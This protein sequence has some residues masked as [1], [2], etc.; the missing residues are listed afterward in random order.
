M[1]A[2]ATMKV[3]VNAEKHRLSGQHRRNM[4][5]P[6]ADPAQ[7][8]VRT[9]SPEQP[10]QNQHQPCEKQSVPAFVP[11]PQ[12][13]PMLT[14]TL[15]ATHS[16][17]SSASCSP[18]ASTISS[19]SDFGS[20][21]ESVSFSFFSPLFYDQKLFIYHFLL[22]FYKRLGRCIQ[23]HPAVLLMLQ[24]SVAAIHGCTIY[25]LSVILSVAQLIMITFTLENLDWIQAHK[26][27]ML[28]WDSRFPGF[29]FPA[30]D[31]DSAD[32]EDECPDP[33]ARRSQ[34][35]R[36]SSRYWNAQASLKGRDDLVDDGYQSEEC[37]QRWTIRQ[38]MNSTLRKRLAK[39]QQWIPS[40][41]NAEENRIQ[42]DLEQE[43]EDD[44]VSAESQE[45]E[46]RYSS[47]LRRALVRTLSGNIRSTNSKRVTFNEQVLVFGRRRSSQASQLSVSSSAV[48]MTVISVDAARADIEDPHPSAQ[49]EDIQAPTSI[50]KQAEHT[51][52]IS[53]SLTTGDH[54]QLPALVQDELLYQQMI[55]S[56]DVNGSGTSSPLFKL[57]HSRSQ[58][59]EV[60]SPLMSSSS[61][62][63]APP[64][65]VTARARDLKRSISVPMKIGSFLHRHQQHN[66]PSDEPLQ[67]TPRHS[68]TFSE[69]STVS[70]NPRALPSHLA[71]VDSPEVELGTEVPPS[72]RTLPLLSLRARRSLSLGTARPNSHPSARPSAK[73]DAGALLERQGSSSRTNKNFMYRIVHPQRYKRELEQQWTEQ[74]QQRLLALANLQHRHILAYDQEEVPTPSST[75]TKAAGPV[76]CGDAYYYATSAEYIED[77]GAPN[78]VISTS[79][80]ISF[81]QELQRNRSKN[82][83]KSQQRPASYDF[84]CRQPSLVRPTGSGY[85][86]EGD[87]VKSSPRVEQIQ[88][89]QQQQHFSLFKRG[90]KKTG[91]EQRAQ[92][93]NRLHQLFFHPGH[94]QTQSTSSL[95]QPPGAHM[96]SS[97]SGTASEPSD[98][99]GRTTPPVFSSSAAAGAHRLLSRGRSDSRSFTT[100]TALGVPS[101]PA[102]DPIASAP[103]T[104]TCPTVPGLTY[105]SSR[106]PTMEHT[107]FAAFG[108]PSPTQSPMASAPASPRHS[109]SSMPADAIPDRLEAMNELHADVVR[110]HT[111][112]ASNLTVDGD[113][114]QRQQQQ[115]ELLLD[116]EDDLVNS[117]SHDTSFSSTSS[118][119]S[120]N[121]SAPR[122]SR[123]LSFMRRLSL[124][125]KK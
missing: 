33:L 65:P 68:A 37:Q 59:M 18:T 75:G 124:R 43:V 12:S 6:L 94:S 100:F 115:Q 2:I 3:L 36:K 71:I 125:K 46:E 19:S 107:T 106:D 62:A 41:W 119:L 102:Q 29:V 111:F 13:T 77:L 51:H 93:P 22:E 49:Q 91:N 103:G 101:H 89:P 25:L 120:G 108:F 24:Y 16:V 61:S 109:T 11:P 113:T 42:E 60:S 50:A 7:R 96:C 48:L 118:G 57:D 82:L 26:P 32:S 88:L 110:G 97:Q 9:P 64:S 73:S 121:E 44:A 1:S 122:P 116:Q 84:G 55:A 74:E 31:I 104:K 81:P 95:L 78:S 21:S 85:G 35:Q 87:H 83:F 112:L 98:G 28:E 117:E 52:G 105:R 38:S 67:S 5:S 47:R 92:S 69:S 39:Y 4:A 23:Q 63:A 54:A 17:A 79:Y 53:D 99:S 70:Q 27:L 90:S 80:G 58:P 20:A 30:M 34:G 76:L 56:E 8:P 14:I 114:V 123:G 66:Q 86:S 45:L 40:L 72:P 10:P 15:P